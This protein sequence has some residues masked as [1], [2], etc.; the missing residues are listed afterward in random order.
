MEFYFWGQLSGR[1]LAAYIIAL[2]IT[3][4]CSRFRWPAARRRLHSPIGI[5]AVIALF[6]IPLM[7]SA[8]RL[9]LNPTP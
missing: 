8:S 4:T 1:L 9:A 6:A 5:T 2:L 3:L 7:V